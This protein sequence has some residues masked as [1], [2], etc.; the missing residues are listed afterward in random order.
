MPFSL[1]STTS[2]SWPILFGDIIGTLIEH[3]EHELG[4]ST[5]AVPG[6]SHSATRNY[7]LDFPHHRPIYYGWHIML[8]YR[9]WTRLHIRTNGWPRVLLNLPFYSQWKHTNSDFFRSDLR[10]SFYPPAHTSDTTIS[11]K[12]QAD[13]GL[14]CQ[15]AG[16]SFLHP[17]NH[18]SYDKNI[19]H[20]SSSRRSTSTTAWTTVCNWT[21][22]FFAA[23]YRK[24]HSHCGGANRRA[25]TATNLFYTTRR[26]GP[27]SRMEYDKQAQ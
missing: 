9:G 11:G 15:E 24:R 22:C 17:N 23:N 6:L 8:Q 2:C 13:N 18:E 25:W 10:A 21:D 20:T 16:H 14:V 12:N 3:I 5:P 27:S 1:F 19:T 7:S 26:S 4:Q